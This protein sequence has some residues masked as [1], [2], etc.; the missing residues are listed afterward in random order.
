MVEETILQKPKDMLLSTLKLAFLVFL[1]CIATFSFSLLG[2]GV[3][4]GMCLCARMSAHELHLSPLFPEA[5]RGRQIP[6]ELQ[7]IGNHSV[8]AM[9]PRRASSALNH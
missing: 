3:F 2:L 7:M 5:G 8:G 6:L 1:K 4:V 9:C